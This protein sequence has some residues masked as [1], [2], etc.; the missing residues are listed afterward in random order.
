MPSPVYSIGRCQQRSVSL[1]LN[2]C[3]SVSVSLRHVVVL[4]ESAFFKLL[5][6]MLVFTILS[7][8][9]FLRAFIYHLMD[10]SEMKTSLLGSDFASITPH[11]SS[12]FPGRVP[13]RA[14]ELGPNTIVRHL[15]LSSL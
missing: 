9:L 15:S 10:C 8:G 2:V 1:S 12:C 5:C 14:Q 6:R 11:P 13:D 3:L 4:E 7:N